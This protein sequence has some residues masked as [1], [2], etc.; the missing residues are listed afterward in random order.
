M[1][2]RYNNDTII[3]IP[4]QGLISNFSIIFAL[5]G[6]GD[7]YPDNFQVNLLIK[8]YYK[9]KVPNDNFIKNHLFRGPLH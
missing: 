7:N 4:D 5:H 3:H 2:V 8:Y 9:Y 1:S 6:M